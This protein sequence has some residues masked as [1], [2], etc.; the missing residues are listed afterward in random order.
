MS[1]MTS[2]APCAL[3]L[4]LCVDAAAF[5]QSRSIPEDAVPDR[6]LA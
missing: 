6:W 5:G 2:A 4:A 1:L 3:L